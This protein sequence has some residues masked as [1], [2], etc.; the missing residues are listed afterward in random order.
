M[1]RAPST[2]AH[3]FEDVA[4]EGA[5]LG[6]GVDCHCI[7]NLATWRRKNTGATRLMGIGRVL[8]GT[9]DR[10]TVNSFRHVTMLAKTDHTLVQH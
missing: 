4:H 8:V 5:M 3:R 1:N 2:C 10:K 9:A 6:R 7:E